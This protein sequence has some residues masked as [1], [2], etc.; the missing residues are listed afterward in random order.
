MTK[1]T[2]RLTERRRFP[3]GRSFALFALPFFF[4]QLLLH[5][6]KWGLMQP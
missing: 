2:G 6:V 1:L 5:T 3:W 4:G